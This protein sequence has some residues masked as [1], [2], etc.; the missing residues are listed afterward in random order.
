MHVNTVNL[1]KSERDSCESFK[2]EKSAEIPHMLVLVG[3]ASISY[4][5]S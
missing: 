2:M 4:L 5:C 3:L 1:G